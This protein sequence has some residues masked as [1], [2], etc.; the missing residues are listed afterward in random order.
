V[1]PLR[2][3]FQNPRRILRD[4]IEPGMTVLDV[5]CGAGF[6]SLGMASLVGP[7]GRVVCVDSDAGAIESLNAQASSGGLSER[8]EARVCSNRKL[9]IEDLCNQ[10]DF[11]LAFYVIHHTED[12]DGLMTQV[13]A[14]LR[15]GGKFLVVEPRHHASPAECETV[16]AIARLSGFALLDH[17]KMARNWAALFV[18]NI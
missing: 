2:F 16:D 4:Y 5:G 13:Y 18:K 10:V 15:S 17:P 12:V 14:A 3:L 6:F 1:G 9:E 7:G 8:I 11:A